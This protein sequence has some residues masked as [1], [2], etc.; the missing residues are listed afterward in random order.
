MIGKG[1]L[2]LD[3]YVIVVT[4]DVP[5]CGDQYGIFGPLL[6][7]AFPKSKL[8]QL[9]KKQG[10]HCADTV[11]CATEMEKLGAIRIKDTLLKKWV[12]IYDWKDTT[13]DEQEFLDQGDNEEEAG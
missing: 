10:G 11:V 9:S 7:W 13:E 1:K 3:K 4:Q 12:T 2:D 6:C 5:E 8:G